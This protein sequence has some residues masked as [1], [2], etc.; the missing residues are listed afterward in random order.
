MVRLR[1]RHMVGLRIRLRAEVGP[2]LVGVVC[3]RFEEAEAHAV[4]PRGR[5]GDASEVRRGGA[6]A[7]VEARVVVVRLG[8]RDGREA[9]R[10]V[11]HL[12]RGWS[13]GWAGVVGFGSGAS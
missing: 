11:A 9:Q 8:G 10:G 2:N 6:G 1:V 12:V 5:R 13:E 3:V 7:A 4:Q